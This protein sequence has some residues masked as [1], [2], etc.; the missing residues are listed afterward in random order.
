MP[1]SRW[2]LVVSLLLLGT[3][4]ATQARAAD[5]RFPWQKIPGPLPAAGR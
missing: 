3:A 4:L 5:E 2:T 1:I